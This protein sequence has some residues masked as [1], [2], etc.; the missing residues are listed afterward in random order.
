MLGD[1][2]SQ[3]VYYSPLL[4]LFCG[5]YL[6]GVWVS[7]MTSLMLVGIGITAAILTSL[8][9]K[10]WIILLAVACSLVGIAQYQ[11]AARSMNNLE[12]RIFEANEFAGTVVSYAKDQKLGTAYLIDLNGGYRVQILTNLN[13]GLRD[14]ISFSCYLAKPK[15]S[16]VFDR[17][18]LLWNKGAIASCSTDSI[19]I[20]G[21]SWGW[22]IFGIPARLREGMIKKFETLSPGNEAGLYQG[23]ILGETSGLSKEVQ[24]WFKDTGTTHVMAVSGFNVS[25]MIAVISLAAQK[26]ALSRRK[27]VIFSIGAI[28]LLWGMVGSSASVIRAALMGIMALT[29]FLLYRYANQRTIL[30]LVATAMTIFNPFALR[31]DIGF[32]LSFVATYALIVFT[33]KLEKLLF[34]DGRKSKIEQFICSAVLPGLVAYTATAPLIWLHFGRISWTA[35][36]ANLVIAPMIPLMMA[37]GM[38]GVMAGWALWWM[39]PLVGLALKICADAFLW[40]VRLFSTIEVRGPWNWQGALIILTYLLIIGI[41]L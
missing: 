16:A 27:R 11:L 38:V 18:M 33:P 25:I 20:T 1:F 35:I 34:N 15:P 26:L 4:R 21:K 5:M 12:S 37:V 40:I 19:R 30:I 36:V 8:I 3:K 29:A 31:A 28:L 39:S 24:Q 10:R 22:I 14:M 23:I 9:T 7:P 41:I 13:L 32:Q 2:M 17:Q 6:L